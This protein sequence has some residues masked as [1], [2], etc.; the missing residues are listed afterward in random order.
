M[1]ESGQKKFEVLEFQKNYFS[2]QR[3]NDGVP[4]QEA[5]EKNKVTKC[6]SFFFSHLNF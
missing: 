4:K 3:Y 5:G 6:F 1:F 2:P